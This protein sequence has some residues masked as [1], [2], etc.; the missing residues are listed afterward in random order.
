MFFFGVLGNGEIA[1]EVHERGRV[2]T[3]QA[4]CRTHRVDGGEQQM[5][6]RVSHQGNYPASL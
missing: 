5:H 3:E 4:V 6:V 1:F 2:L